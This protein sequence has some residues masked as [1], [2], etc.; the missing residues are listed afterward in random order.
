MAFVLS[1]LAVKFGKGLGEYCEISHCAAQ[2][3]KLASSTNIPIKERD[4]RAPQLNS[5]HIHE[6]IDSTPSIATLHHCKYV[7]PDDSP[8][9]PYPPQAK[10][11]ISNAGNSV[12]QHQNS[13]SCLVFICPIERVPQS[14]FVICLC[15][16]T[17]I[18]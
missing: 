9:A 8:P 11:K 17:Q 15:V 10:K 1:H 13:M 14:S 18:L 2:K 4:T 7:F 5:C 16:K 6:P 12:C 3:R